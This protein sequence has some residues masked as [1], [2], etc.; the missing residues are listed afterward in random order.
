MRKMTESFLRAA[1][2]GE[3]Q[4]HMKY[5]IFADRAEKDGRANTARLFRAIAYAERVH[6][7]NHFKALGDLKCGVENLEAAIAGEDFE[8]EEMYPAYDAVARLQAEKGAIKSVHWALEAEKVHRTLYETAKEAEEKGA[9]SSFK[10]IHICAECGHT[11]EGEAPERCP[12]C[13]KPK[14]IFKG[15]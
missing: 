2:A 8:V 10:T 12:L 15:F 11:V 9:D 5:T 7:T 14:E 1:F 6:A 3:S 4:A 13:G